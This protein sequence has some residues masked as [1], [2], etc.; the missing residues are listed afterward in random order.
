MVRHE[1]YE[2]IEEESRPLYVGCCCLGLERSG[3]LLCSACFAWA[4]VCSAPIAH[5]HMHTGPHMQL[6]YLHFLYICRYA[7]SMPQMEFKQRSLPIV[8]KM[9]AYPKSGPTNLLMWT[10]GVGTHGHM[11]RLICVHLFQYTEICTSAR[12]FLP[13]FVEVNLCVC[14]LLINLVI[15][16][17]SASVSQFFSRFSRIYPEGCGKSQSQGNGRTIPQRILEAA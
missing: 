17:V 11:V 6:F 13:M 5:K 10:A 3:C 1:A 9:D 14:V 2:E 12:I 7:N 8:P 16:N 4:K 15:T